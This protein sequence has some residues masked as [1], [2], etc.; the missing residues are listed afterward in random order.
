[1]ININKLTL[2]I[3]FLILVLS[4]TPFWKYTIPTAL[5]LLAMLLFFVKEATKEFYS[6]LAPLALLLLIPMITS[7]LNLDLDSNYFILRDG[8]YFIQPLLFI[9]IG[10]LIYFKIDDLQQLLKTFLIA[11][12]VVTIFKMSHLLM[13]P[14]LFLSLDIGS[15]GERY[16][17]RT[18]ILSVAIIVYGKVSDTRILKTS[19]ENIILIFSIITVIISFTRSIYLALFFILFLLFIKNIKAIKLFFYT[20]IFF[21]LIILFSSSAFLSQNINIIQ[22]SN[23]SSLLGKSLNSLNEVLIRSYNS[24]AEILTN[25]R[26]YEAF[27]GL[28]KYNDGNILQLVFG[29]GLGAVVDNPIKEMSDTAMK[30]IPIFHNGYVTILLKTGIIG[31][32]IYIFWIYKILKLSTEDTVSKKDKF[33]CLML[34]SYAFILVAF[35]F[36]VQGIYVNTSMAFMLILLGVLLQAKIALNRDFNLRVKA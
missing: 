9:L 10:S 31:L 19:Y 13:N 28:Q 20:N 2:L 7:L 24:N 6:F 30:T 34:R 16:Y 35:T 17:N 33:L 29:Q 32:F 25:W 12:F 26:G 23:D 11:S 36:V 4:E 21:V 22:T 8:Y 14:H 18:A 3:L 5:P 27:L 15:R 1:M